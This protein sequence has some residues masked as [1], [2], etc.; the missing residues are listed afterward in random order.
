MNKRWPDHRRY[1]CSSLAGTAPGV[2][3]LAWDP[4]GSR[5]SSVGP[6]SAHRDGGAVALWVI[7][8]AAVDRQALSIRT[9]HAVNIYPMAVSASSS[10]RDSYKGYIMNVC[11]SVFIASSQV[12]ER[13][14]TGRRVQRRSPHVPRLV[15]QGHKPTWMARSGQCLSPGPRPRPLGP[16]NFES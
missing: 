5:L 11:T 6:W 3:A 14:L 13:H 15:S 4:H 7:L 2:W 9:N 10:R 1:L 8:I 16:L 12:V